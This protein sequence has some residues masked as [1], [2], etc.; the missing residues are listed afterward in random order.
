MIINVEIKGHFKLTDED[1]EGVTEEQ[2]VQFIE[3]TQ[4]GIREMLLSETHPEQ[5]PHFE[6]K[7]S[8]A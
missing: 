4:E 7:L 8:K 3:G 5:E 1:L 6:V 2:F